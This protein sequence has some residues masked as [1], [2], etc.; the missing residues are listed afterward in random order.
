VFG[1]ELTEID[2]AILPAHLSASERPKLANYYATI[3]FES[4]GSNITVGQYF[5]LLLR[6]WDG[7]L[8]KDLIPTLDEMNEQASVHD[9][10]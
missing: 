1:A 7:L 5:Y 10:V 2:D 3:K 9:S 8:Y 6:F 4:N